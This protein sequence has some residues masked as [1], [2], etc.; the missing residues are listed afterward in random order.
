[1]AVDTKRSAKRR[2][3][4]KDDTRNDSPLFCTGKVEYYVRSWQEIFGLDMRCCRMDEQATYSVTVASIARIRDE[5]ILLGRHGI[6]RS[7]T[8][9]DGMACVGGDSL[10]F[11]YHFS[12]GLVI[13]N[14]SDPV[15]HRFLTHNLDLVRQQLGRRCAAQSTRLGSV[16]DMWGDSDGGINIADASLSSFRKCDALYLDPEWGGT[17]YRD[18]G[19]SL[20]MEIS[21]KPLDACVCDAFRASRR[22]RWVLLK[23]PCNFDR[24]HISRI[25]DSDDSQ[26]L[27]LSALT[28]GASTARGGLN[29]SSYRI[30]VR[31]EEK[32]IFVVIE[33]VD[34][35]AASREGPNTAEKWRQSLPTDVNLTTKRKFSR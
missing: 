2:R 21:G 31:G 33:R 19:R 17:G 18:A 9:L 25:L 6:P 29:V 34:S 24:E 30:L 23:L 32:M 27:Q 1:M 5:D 12:D 7:V 16:L 28:V 20:H 8:I 13:S 26:R 15:R 10:S 22:L 14:E 4:D 3:A 35:Q 11:M